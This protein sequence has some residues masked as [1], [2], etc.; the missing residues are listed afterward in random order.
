MKLLDKLRSVFGKKPETYRGFTREQ[1]LARM[2][3]ELR[4]S[5]RPDESME[6]M[7]MYLMGRIAMSAAGSPP[8]CIQ[9]PKNM[10][11]ERYKVVLALAQ[12]ELVPMPRSWTDITCYGEVVVLH[13]IVVAR[14]LAAA[15]EEMRK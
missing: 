14:S 13:K 8:K 4:K 7:W 3:E 11:C 5:M 15:R 12:E 10:P 1:L 6:A 2:P 9:M